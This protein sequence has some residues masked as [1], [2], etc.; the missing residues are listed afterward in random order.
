[1]KS[2]LFLSLAG[3]SWAATVT[4]NWD[5]TWVEA[6]PDGFKR[7]VIGNMPFN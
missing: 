7:P 5:I 2:F 1:M 3:A 6:D 4:Y